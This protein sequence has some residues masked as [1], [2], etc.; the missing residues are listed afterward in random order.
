VS[1]KKNKPLDITSPSLEIL[2]LQFLK[3]LVQDYLLDDVIYF[4]LTTDV[5]PLPGVT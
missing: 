5:R 2:F 4:I 3:N 1:Q